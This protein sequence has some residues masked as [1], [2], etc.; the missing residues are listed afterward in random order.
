MGTKTKVPE[1]GN[2]KGK[3]EKRDKEL[4]QLR[5]VNQSLIGEN[6]KLREEIIKLKRGEGRDLKPT[7]LGAVKYGHVDYAGQFHEDHAIS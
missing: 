4:K 5:K 3:D 7:E 2:L 1:T 6:K